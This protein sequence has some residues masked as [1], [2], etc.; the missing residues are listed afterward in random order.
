MSVSFVQDTDTSVGK[1]GGKLE[2]L[3]AGGIVGWQASK[4]S[5]A[6]HKVIRNLKID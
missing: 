2:H 4:F 3:L 1:N 5:L 6:K